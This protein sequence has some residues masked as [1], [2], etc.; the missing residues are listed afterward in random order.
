MLSTFDINRQMLDLVAKFEPMREVI[1]ASLVDGFFTICFIWKSYHVHTLLIPSDAACHRFANCTIEMDA[2][3]V[4]NSC[5]GR[6]FTQAYCIRYLIR[7]IQDVNTI[8]CRRTA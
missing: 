2:T 7:K 8:D 6:P 4:L 3:H 1:A 5:A